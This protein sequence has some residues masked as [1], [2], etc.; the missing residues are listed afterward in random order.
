MGINSIKIKYAFG[1][2]SLCGLLVGCK[3]NTDRE[4]SSYSLPLGY[5]M[6]ELKTVRLADELAEISGIAWSQNKLLA[7]E[8][9]SSVIFELDPNSGI[10]IKKEKF[11]KNRDVED[12]L[13]ND[14]EAWI[15]RSNGNLYRVAHF[16][17]DSAATTIFEFPVGES[18]DLEAFV[19]SKDKSSILL[20]C[21]VCE[22]DLNPDKSSVFRFSLETLSFEAS[23]FLTIEKSQLKPIL[24]KKW[25]QVKIQPSAAAYHPITGELFLLSSTDKWL[26]VLDQQWNPVSFH[27]L[28]P[29]LFWQA[30]GM[31]F[32]EMGNLFISNE[33]GIRSANWHFIPYTQ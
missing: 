21:K 3:T 12:I 11:E 10:I 22:W 23:P 5:S 4:L 8:D 16:L 20:F 25:K 33:A 18:R 2:L 7:I 17:K 13:V 31:T 15:L 6:Q 28:D 32:D 30:E 19:L 26:M 24:P 29:K 9:E 27:F 14:S 1:F